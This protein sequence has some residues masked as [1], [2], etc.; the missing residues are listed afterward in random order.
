MSVTLAKGPLKLDPNE[1]FR[2][3]TAERFRS[4]RLNVLENG[5]LQIR[6]QD[7]GDLVEKFWGDSDYEFWT[8]I[9]AESLPKLAETL[10]REKHAGDPKATDSLR[11]HCKEHSIDHTW[12]SWA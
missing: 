7:M 6:T 8:E 2:E 12:Q 11:E 9:P 3:D 10:L 4:V 5:G 1:L